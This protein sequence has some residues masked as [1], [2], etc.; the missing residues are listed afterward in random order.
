MKNTLILSLTRNELVYF[1]AVIGSKTTSGLEEDP[2]TDLDDREI[3]EHLNSGEQS[4]INRGLLV[5]NEDSATLDDTLVALVGSSV[6]PDATFVLTSSDPQG[7]QQVHYFHATAEI[8]VERTAPGSDTFTFTYLPDADALRSRL[9][10]LLEP[11]QSPPSSDSDELDSQLSLPADAMARF[12]EQCKQADGNA[13]R[14]TLIHAGW[15][16]DA[17]EQ[18]A[19]DCGAS[20]SWI[21]FTAWNLR[22]GDMQGLG[23]V[24]VLQGKDACWLIEN[25]QDNP[26]MFQVRVTP[27]TRCKK[28]L[29]ALIEPLLQIYRSD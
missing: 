1:L 6:V 16:V 23:P 22:Y 25:S 8:L 11:L 26:E 13:A 29:M 10:A 20:P 15:P 2:F 17:A 7:P 18:L 9:E 12:L 28:P 5:I 3:A 21:G 27:A 19:N 14:Q 4:L 24:I